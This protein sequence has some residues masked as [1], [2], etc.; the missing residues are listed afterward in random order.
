M[1]GHL[2]RCCSVVMIRRV[3]PSRLASRR[4]LKWNLSSAVEALLA[5]PFPA[6]QLVAPVGGALL[7][8]PEFCR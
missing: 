8:P 5:Q 3:M 4:S 1:Q 2:H 7:L 6:G